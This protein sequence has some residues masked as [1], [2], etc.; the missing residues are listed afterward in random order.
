MKELVRRKADVLI[1]PGS[2]IALKSVVAATDR[3]P[4][5]M[6]AIDYDPVALHYI[7]SL[8]RPGGNVTGVFFQQVELAMK[9]LQVMRDV[10]PS[11]E[12]ASVFWDA[13]SWRNS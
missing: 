9:R 4:I 3:L 7:T 2:E 12:A 11:V 13:N 5:V 6:I 1:A 8:A 10:L